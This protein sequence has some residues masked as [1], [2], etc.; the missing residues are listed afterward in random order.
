MHTYCQQEK[1]C[2]GLAGITRSYGIQRPTQLRRPLDP[3]RSRANALV[4][5]GID[6]GEG[7]GRQ[8]RGF[9]REARLER[10]EPRP[11]RARGTRRRADGASAPGQGRATRGLGYWAA[12]NGSEHDG[13]PTPA[14]AD[15]SCLAVAGQD[16]SR[17]GLQD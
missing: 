1:S 6:A 5:H 11:E 7:R 12:R 10:A 15:S 16:R 9:A 4:P 2:S 14:T 17:F 3:E 8:P 13:G